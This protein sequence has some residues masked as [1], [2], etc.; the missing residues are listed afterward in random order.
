M[1]ISTIISIAFFS[2]HAQSMTVRE[3]KN[4]QKMLKSVENTMEQK[5][6]QKVEQKDEQKSERPFEQ[7]GERKQK[8][9]FKTA[10]ESFSK[11]QKLRAK[12]M[13]KYRRNP[14]LFRRIKHL[15][16]KC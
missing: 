5:V 15:H 10:L 1:K 16:L 11:C 3:H 13:I 7:N 12:L 2:V 9:S 4:I 8:L 6:D 14:R